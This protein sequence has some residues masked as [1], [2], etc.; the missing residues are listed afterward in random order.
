VASIQSG[1]VT[2]AAAG[3]RQQV[4]VTPTSIRAIR[5]E[6]DDGNTNPIFIG[7]SAVAATA[8]GVR[9]ASAGNNSDWIKFEGQTPGDLSHFYVDVTTSGEKAQY[10]AILAL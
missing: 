7:D 10:L 3:T 1:S 5:F 2:V 8:Y 9:L 6:S 4:T